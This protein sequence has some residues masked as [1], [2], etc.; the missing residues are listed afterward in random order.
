[1]NASS[2]TGRVV[3]GVDGSP[4]S[5]DAVRWAAGYARLTGAGLE[6]VTSWTTPQTFGTSLGIGFETMQVDWENTAREIQQTALSQAFPDGSEEL[7]GRV[8]ESHPAVALITA[9]QGADLLV[10]GSRGHGGFAGML[11]GSVSG[12]VVAHA[13]CPVVVVRHETDH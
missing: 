9:A 7:T 12:H 13:S 2:T 6:A 10:V 8:V 1:M 11:L 3:V 4:A 5:I